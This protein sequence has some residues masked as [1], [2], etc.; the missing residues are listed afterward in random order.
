MIDVRAQHQAATDDAVLALRAREYARLDAR[1]HTYLDYTA[2]G[3]YAE[4]QVREHEA[5][6]R[7]SVFG[8]PHSTNPASLASTE[9][10]ERARAAV[11]AY[12]N[13]A[14]DEY[15]VVF[16]PNASGA[17]RLVGESYPFA[18]GGRLLLSADNHN[19]VN[20]IREFARS[21]GTRV[22]YA[23][24][25]PGSLRLDGAALLRQL[26]RGLPAHRRL[27]AFPA[28][29]NFSGVQHPLAWIGLA[30]ARG[31][32]VLL[33]A[34]AFVPTNRLDLSRW[35]PDFVALSF[36]KLLGYPTG[37]GCLIARRAALAALRRPWFA[38]G[39]ITVASVLADGHYL[40]EGEAAFEDGTIDFLSL[41]AVEL[42]LRYVESVGID[43]IHERVQRLT[44]RLLAQLARLRHRSGAPLV[45][46]YGPETMDSRGGTVAFNVLRLDGSVLDYRLVEA[47]ANRRRISLRTGC[48]CNPGASE[49]AFGFTSRELEPLFGRPEQLTV[50]R[51]RDLFPG[52]AV[53]A[54]RV[55]LGL[56]TT[57]A[58]VARFIRLVRRFGT[59][60]AGPALGYR[61]SSADTETLPSAT[62][63][64]RSLRDRMP[65]LR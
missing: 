14:P 41:P 11:L 58:D 20:G 7:G 48:F 43:A 62:R 39:T 57:P 25:K 15:T 35:Q 2:G 5:L 27:L 59:T 22:T 49:T 64:V 19:S 23:P 31:W 9:L 30:R 63:R 13:A 24:L 53:G 32:D 10:A 51:L 47:E 65:S 1:G 52:R 61:R 4:S 3:L 46:L 42:G 45:R 6:L 33:D 17:L 34:A 50:D 44:S 8:N 28:Q 56:A 12:F 36:Y 18:P 21:R 29:S 38:G 40:A 55:S 37:V 26:E 54:V 16:T 60:A